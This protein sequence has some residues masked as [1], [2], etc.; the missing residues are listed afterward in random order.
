[1]KRFEFSIDSPKKEETPLAKQE[2]VLNLEKE[3]GS[4]N[5]REIAKRE[6]ILIGYIAE[7]LKDPLINAKKESIRLL[8]AFTIFMGASTAYAEGVVEKTELADG[9]DQHIAQLL[10]SSK[11]KQSAQFDWKKAIEKI[12]ISIGGKFQHKQEYETSVMT[13]TLSKLGNEGLSATEYFKVKHDDGTV[14][15]QP[16]QY[17]ASLT[18]LSGEVQTAYYDKDGNILVNPEVDHS[19]VET[20]YAHSSAAKVYIE[21]IKTVSSNGEFFNKLKTATEKLGAMEKVEILQMVAF[22]LN[23]SYNFDM[24][25]EDEHY[26]ISDDVTL[27]VLRGN[28][29]GKN[30][31]DLSSPAAL[32]TC[33]NISTYL[34]KVAKSMGM[35]GWLQTGS[36]GGSNDVWMGSVVE[37]DGKKEIVYVTYWGD[38]V[39]TGTLNYKDS[40][41]I[42][43]RKMQSIS[44]FNSYVGNEESTL[45]EVASKAQDNIL[46][47]ANVRPVGDILEKNIAGGN[48]SRD[49]GLEISINPDVQQ[50]QF[51]KDHF[52]LAIYNFSDVYAD[53]YQSMEAMQAIRTNFSF[54]GDNFGLEGDA[55]VMNISMKDFAGSRG[56]SYVDIIGRVAG[57]FI[58]SREL[59]KGEYGKLVLN[60]GTTIQSAIKRALNDSSL[61][62][63][64]ELKMEG[65][66]GARL[67]YFSPNDSN[68][69]YIG[70]SDT[71][72]FQTNN[73]QEQ[74]VVI[75]EGIKKFTVGGSVKVHEAAIL[76]IDAARSDYAWGREYDLKAEAGVGNVV[77][78]GE[79]KTA[80]S[81]FKRFY[82]DSDKVG[83][84]VGYKKN[85]WE[86]D[87]IGFKK[88]E[89]YASAEKVNDYGAEI[90][91]KII[92]WP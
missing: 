47:A 84:K 11:E 36:S 12:E 48:F 59:T 81:E 38:F 90:K 5:L 82:P 58:D 19:E 91:L 43:E 18:T 68:K 8:T 23:K 22:D 89:Q 25:K 26:A 50:L 69:F 71:M 80:N 83:I 87:L 28:Y 16:L 46:D 27:N 17:A 1:M 37:R 3:S 45:F 14:N 67:T 2:S 76:N 86:V 77:L 13:P 6:N 85:A 61:N 66:A 24:S 20:E 79:Y 4:E 78:G 75:A 56:K 72:Q 64:T 60:Y 30:M 15:L 9:D 62:S 54:N 39:P 41:G 44:A 73:M 52:G 29:I 49:N 55:T 35:E 65:A 70:A 88:T 40:R 51:T 10:E 32:G 57:S 33:G 92:L 7:K 21:S 53:P 42:M 74:K 31:E 63:G 34:V